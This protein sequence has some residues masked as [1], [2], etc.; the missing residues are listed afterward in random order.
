[1]KPHTPE[2]AEGTAAFERFRKAVKAVLSVPKSALPPRP[3]RAK[4]KAAKPKG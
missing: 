4:K 1:M 2:I 3:H